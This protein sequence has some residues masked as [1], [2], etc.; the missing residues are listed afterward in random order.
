MPI[1]PPDL[2]DAETIAILTEVYAASL[3]QMHLDGYTI[4]V[5]EREEG[6][7]CLCHRIIELALA[8]E[9]DPQVLLHRVLADYNSE[10]AHRG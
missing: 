5:L 8:G 3:R 1:E 6:P 2:F 4:E 9:R 10:K 7:Q